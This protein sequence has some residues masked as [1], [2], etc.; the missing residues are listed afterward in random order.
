VPTHR[1]RTNTTVHRW[2]AEEA[3]AEDRRLASTAP[4][5]LVVLKLAGYRGCWQL[6]LARSL[7]K[8]AGALCRC[9]ALRA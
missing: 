5:A 1:R 8:P 6:V 3:V 2:V 9:R 4:A 7:R